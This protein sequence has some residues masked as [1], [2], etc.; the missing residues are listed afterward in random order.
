M[1]THLFC[2]EEYTY[3]KLRDLTRPASVDSLV[4]R[5]GSPNCSSSRSTPCLS[6]WQPI[7]SQLVRPMSLP[8][9]MSSLPRDMSNMA[10]VTSPMP[11]MKTPTIPLVKKR[12]QMAN[13]V[14]QLA[15]VRHRIRYSQKHR[16]SIPSLVMIMY[17][18]VSST[19]LQKGAPNYG[20]MRI[21]FT[22]VTNYMFNWFANSGYIYAKK[23]VNCLQ[24]KGCF[25][26]YRIPAPYHQYELT[27]IEESISL[28]TER[29]SRIGFI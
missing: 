27:T 20:I 23:V 2:R 19:M 25:R 26:G 21:P 15:K 12:L 5:C 11:P 22:F 4:C 29:G 8:R 1:K 28:N 17:M 18:K 7:Q 10:A 14:K 16:S 13:Y 9:D 24:G 6:T 3:R